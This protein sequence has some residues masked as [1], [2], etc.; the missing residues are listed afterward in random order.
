MKT[1]V[2]KAARSSQENHLT[3][4]LFLRS[5]AEHSMIFGKHEMQELNLNC[6]SIEC[7]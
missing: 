2:D 7:N 4:R 5:R 1:A 3:T 6:C